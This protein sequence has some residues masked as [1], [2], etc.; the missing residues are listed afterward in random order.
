MTEKDEKKRKLLQSRTASVTIERLQLLS[1]IENCS[2]GQLLDSMVEVFYQQA[3]ADCKVKE[4]LKALQ[5]MDDGVP[6]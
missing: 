2:I 3:I 1:S 6:L 4:Y 5:S